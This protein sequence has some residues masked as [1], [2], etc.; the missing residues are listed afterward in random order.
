M[1]GLDLLEKLGYSVFKKRILID[2]IKIYAILKCLVPICA[3]DL[4]IFL[5]LCNYYLRFIS[6][7]AYIAAPHY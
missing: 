1:F 7:V 4:E 2:P 6:C 3:K 5:G